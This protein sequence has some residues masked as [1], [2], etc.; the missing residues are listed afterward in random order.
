MFYPA[1]ESELARTMDDLL[2]EPPARRRSWSGAMVPH[3]GLV[4]SGR[5]AAQ[6]FQQIEFPETILILAPRHT[7]QGV[8]WAVAPHD[9]WSLPGGNVPSDPQLAR[10]LAEAI[11]DLELDAAAHAREHAIEV[12]LPLLASLA[13]QSRVV[14]I[15]IGA[16]NLQR[17]HQFATAMAAVL[18]GREDRTLLVI[19]SDMNHFAN[20]TET[21]RVDQLALR[22]LE[23]LDPAE[24]Y[25]TV[26]QNQISMCGV[27][28]AMIV[29]DTL[30]Q[31]DR[32]HECQRV[33]YATSADAS[34]DTSRVVGYA[35]MLLG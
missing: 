30:R 1:D 21:R 28:P 16:G 10:E 13:P 24:L 27:L 12:Q 5:L 22:A 9:A 8:E 7:G 2:G 20:D 33:G 26:R 11:D 23:S 3:A 6:V 14:G 4:Y 15:T 17:C 34:G 18:R 25:N 29:T 35:G 19:S 32:L 31:L